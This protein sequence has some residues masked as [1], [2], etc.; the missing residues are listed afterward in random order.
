MFPKVRKMAR[1]RAT[2]R[3][4]KRATRERPTCSRMPAKTSA[5]TVRAFDKADCDAELCFESLIAVE[6]PRRRKPC[7]PTAE[8]RQDQP[9][10]AQSRGGFFAPS[11]WRDFLTPNAEHT[12]A[13]TPR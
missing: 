4:T 6:M 12:K 2:R 10:L 8:V 11:S 3:R 1:R 7:Q 9:G 13:T 5:A